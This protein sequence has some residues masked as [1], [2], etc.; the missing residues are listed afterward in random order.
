MEVRK[1]STKNVNWLGWDIVC[2]EV[3]L[4]TSYEVQSENKPRMNLVLEEGA[5]VDF[6]GITWNSQPS[7][8]NIG[9]GAG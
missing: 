8:Q 5:K 4:E 1:S 6:P 3:F 7:L 2:Q 9:R